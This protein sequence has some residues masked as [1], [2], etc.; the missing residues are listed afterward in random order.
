MELKKAPHVNL[1]S[2][3]TLSLLLGLVVSIS[4]L[5]VALEWRST[6][7]KAVSLEVINAFELDEA[8][9]I[10]DEQ[11]EEQPEEPPQPEQAIEVQMPEEFKVV[12]NDK[13]VVA[14]VFVSADEGKAIPPPAAVI[15]TPAKVVEEVDEVFEIVEEPCE[16]PGGQT[17]LMKY[18]NGAIQYP[19]VAI[20]NGIQGRVMISFVVEKNGKPTDVKVLR[21]IDPSLDKEAVRVVS[22]MPAWKPGKQGGKPVRQRFTL[23]VTFRLQ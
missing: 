19:E 20:D 16:F 9:I 7:S 6:S 1:E 18:L 15:G 3:K 17:A 13:E 21:G 23:P 12:D 14:A 5:Y 8:L 11:Q 2:Q 4:F 22:G 10:E